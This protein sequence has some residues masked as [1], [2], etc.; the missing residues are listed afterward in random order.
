MSEFG[1]RA[2]GVISALRLHLQRAVRR[3]G[4]ETTRP[5]PGGRRQLR[6]REE[7]KEAERQIRTAFRQCCFVGGKTCAC[8]SADRGVQRRPLPAMAVC[9]CPYWKSFLL[10]SRRKAAECS[11]FQILKTQY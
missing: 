7:P 10:T 9:L 8:M 4:S 1:Q 5:G 2:A 3:H 6:R 11:E